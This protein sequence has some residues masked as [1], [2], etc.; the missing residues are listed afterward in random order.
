MI[1]KITLLVF[2]IALVS[3]ENEA[4]KNYVTIS[5]KITNHLGKDGFIRAEGYKKE[6]KISKE[7][8]FSDTLHLKDE[9][10]MFTF[11]DGNEFTSLYLKNGDDIKMTLDTKEFDETIKYTGNGAGN[12]NYLA[13]KSLLRESLL[14]EA[15]FSLEKKDF[16]KKVD[17]IIILFN[18]KLNTAK[19]LDDDFVAIE[20][21][22][23]EKLKKDILEEFDSVIAVK[24]KFNSFIGKPSPDFKNYENYNGGTTSLKDLR[25]KYVYVDVWATWCGPCK[26]EIPFL[27]ELEKEYHDKNIEFLSISVDNG[28]G[29]KDNS[30]ELSKEGWR[31]MIADKKMGGIQLFSDKAW[32]SDFVKGYKINGIPR[33]IL[34]DPNG[35]VVE[36]N[37]SRPS[38]PKTKE[39]FNKLLK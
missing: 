33:F 2:A 30:L 24:E 8:V 23:L 34:I 17:E 21:E 38:S 13:Q 35:N 15:L 6:I 25:G 1:K 39:L 26:A 3:C 27:K 20:K 5:G 32:K 10:A 19:N 14:T 31:K 29:Y 12:S 22:N 36:A 4:P 37:S 7:G 11:S 9:G 16:T 18:K 28:R